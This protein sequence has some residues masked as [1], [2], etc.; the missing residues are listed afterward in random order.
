MY[1]RSS[2][3]VLAAL[4]LAACSAPAPSGMNPDVVR[5][6]L[7]PAASASGPVLQ[8]LD[9]PI[10]QFPTVTS[11]ELTGIRGNL[12][13]A[14]YTVTSGATGAAIYNRTTGLWTGLQFPGARSTATYGPDVTSTSF[15]AV[16]S[17][18]VGGTHINH[19]FLYD[20]STNA[21]TTMDAPASFCGSKPCNET[22][23]HSIYGNANFKLVG[24]A[25]AVAGKPA[26]GYPASGHA[27]LYDSKTKKFTK[28]DV[29]NA[30]ATTAY[31]IWIGGSTVAV[32]GGFTDSKGVHAYVR[33][34]AGKQQVVYNYPN[35]AITH[36]E[37]I[38]G[39]GSAGNYNVIGDYVSVKNKAIGGFFLPIRNW[40]AGAPVAIGKVSANSVY[41]Q[42]VIGVYAAAGHVNGY[43]TTIP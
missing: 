32:A 5:G 15:R 13:T 12:I 16:G 20:G 26:P 17:Y 1:A 42:T 21:Y 33:N 11:T 2:F 4:A 27:I 24:N 9:V 23:L 43:I 35:A 6:G 3:F 31:G 18:I 7:L 36:F 28:I 39:A 22:I 19:G 40:K 25:D 14:L 41:Q 37:G 8:T 30:A 29:P 10:S 34:L 38:T